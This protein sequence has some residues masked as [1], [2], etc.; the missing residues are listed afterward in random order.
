MPTVQL[1]FVGNTMNL[2]VT[3][4]RFEGGA[5]INDATVTATILNSSGAQISGETWPLAVPYV[6][7]T[8]GNYEVALSE[9]L[10]I[11][12][13]KNYTVEVLAVKDGNEAKWRQTVTAV[14]RKFSQ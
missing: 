11:V 7:S 5:Y 4:L 10:V 9:D 2:K 3:G 6:T 8:D 12:K 1:L 13:D 14:D